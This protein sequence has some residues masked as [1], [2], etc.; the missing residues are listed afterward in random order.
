MNQP[1]E[2][3]TLDGTFPRKGLGNP[4]HLD[5]FPNEM[6]E[7]IFSRH[8]IRRFTDEPIAPE[9]LDLIVDAG[10]RAP[11]GGGCQAVIMLVSQ[12]AEMN[13]SLG[14]ISLQMYKDGYYHVLDAQPSAADDLSMKDGFYG[15][16]VSITV[17]TPSIWDVGRFDAAM[18]ILRNLRKRAKLA[19]TCETCERSSSAMRNPF[20]PT[21][22][23][24]PP[25]MAGRQDIL[26][27]MGQAFEDGPGNPNLSSIIVGP[28][29]SGKTALLACIA[30][31]ALERGWVSARVSALPGML[32]DILERAREAATEFLEPGPGVHV[33][34]VGIPQ[35]IEVEFTRADAGAGNWRTRMNRL[36]DALS[37]HDVGLLITV[38]EVRTDLDE[39][40]Q[41]AATYQHFVQE[42]RKVALVMAGLPHQVAELVDDKSVSFLRRA[43]LR[44]LGRVRDADVEIA[45]RKTV[46]DAGGDIGDDALLACV[47]AAGG[48]PYMMQLVGFWAW[49][50]STDGRITAEAAQRGIRL[51][52]QEI[53]E[54]VFDATYRELSNGDLRFLKAML[55]DSRGSTLPDISVR[56]GVKSNYSTKYKARLLNRG[57]IGE[58]PDGTLDF[59]LPG[60]REYLEGR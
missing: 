54:G 44:R 46:L 28:R 21:F 9:A 7:A 41:L 26:D 37:E 32:E 10:L 11:N 40:V 39:M 43:R 3:P 59:D 25:N 51:A 6:L 19:K 49:D 12:D 29:G 50:S 33:K 56:M 55:P 42:D 2:T 52:R 34:G 8:S 23:K 17:F 35:V 16:P 15:A 1:N 60:F 36:L 53:K 22:G 27:A 24:V 30:S 38:D 58:R 45:L 4:E 31:E 20:T 5:S 18:S 57:V 47:D 13:R 48:F 14:R